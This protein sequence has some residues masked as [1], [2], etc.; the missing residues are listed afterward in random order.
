MPFRRLVFWSHLIV[1]TVT[2]L[3]ILFLAVTGLLLTYER[4]IVAAAEARA[5]TVPADGRPALSADELAIH[6]AGALGPGSSLVFGR[7][8][9][10]PVKATAGRGKQVFLDPFTGA[11]LGTGAERIEAFFGTVEHLHRWFALDGDARAAG[12]A[13]IDAANLAF[14][15]I[16][17]SGVY[18][19]WPR[20]WRW[21]L[22]KTHLT[23]RRNLPTAKARD[24]N[25]HHA[26]GIWAAAPLLLIVVSGVVFSYP[27]ANR[28]VFALYGEEA[29]QGRRGPPVPAPVQPANAGAPAAPVSL[30]TV[31]A[32]A[33]TVDPDWRT[34]TLGL[35]APSDSSVRVTIDAGN[36]AQADLRTDA[37]IS[38]NA[39]HILST[40]GAD[41]LSPGRRARVWLRFIHT[42]EVYGIVGQTVAGLASLAAVL[43]VWTGLSLAWRR[44]IWPLT[45]R[46]A[47]QAAAVR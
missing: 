41:Q 20:R 35:P 29:P 21:P 31:L 43:L 4:Q 27:W 7:D 17:M 46:K 22:L 34:I 24:Y 16:L 26:F 2:G 19:W 6:A 47:R 14:L 25:W 9:Q 10:G 12:R 18:L 40:A 44:L 28:L 33:K 38:R 36:G 45:R 15:F 3:V 23:L 11:V 1:A 39:G 30:D 13:V 42:G 5:F 37:V 32:A 8:P